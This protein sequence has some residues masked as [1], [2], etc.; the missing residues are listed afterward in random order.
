LPQEHSISEDIK[1]RQHPQFWRI[2]MQVVNASITRGTAQTGVEVTFLGEGSDVVAIHLKD[3]NL[4][5]LSDDEV[6]T[7]AKQ[8][9]TQIVAFRGDQGAPLT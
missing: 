7:R 5:S 9:L 3:E 1:G 8:V 2:D 4:A 6:Y